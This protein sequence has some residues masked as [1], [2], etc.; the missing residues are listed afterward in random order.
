MLNGGEGWQ[1]QAVVYVRGEGGREGGSPKRSC[2]D[3]PGQSSMEK[4]KQKKNTNSAFTS[5]ECCIIASSNRQYSPP[6]TDCISSIFCFVFTC[7][8]CCV[9]KQGD[10]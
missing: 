5:S 6:M 8:T 10:I 4:K 7:H 9:F 1:L 3:P 2:Q